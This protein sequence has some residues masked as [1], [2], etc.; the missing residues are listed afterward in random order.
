MVKKAKKLSGSGDESELGRFGS[1]FKAAIEVGESGVKADDAECGHE[2]SLADA[3]ST[4][5]NGALAFVGAAV[6]VER[7]QASES[8]ELLVGEGAEFRESSQEDGSSGGTDALDAAYG[9]V[10]RRACW[11]G[12][13]D[14][15]DRGLDV[16]DLGVQGAQLGGKR[17]AGGREL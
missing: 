17:L 7:S 5:V 4:A 1:G 3:A 13:D 14:L 11:I 15:E 8:A 10:A 9:G 2:Q 16:F 6:V 12:M